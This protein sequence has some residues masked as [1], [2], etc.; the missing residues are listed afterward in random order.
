[1]KLFLYIR[2]SKFL[3]F[4]LGFEKEEEPVKFTWVDIKT[5]VQSQQHRFR[6]SSDVPRLG[7]I[8]GN[9]EGRARE[10]LK[11]LVAVR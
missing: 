4:Q 3:L 1:M 11:Y 5:L 9:L 10:A 7:P 2:L 8:H 6:K